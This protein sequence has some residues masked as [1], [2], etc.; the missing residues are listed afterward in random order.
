MVSQPWESLR[1]ISKIEIVPGPGRKGVRAS[2]DTDYEEIVYTNNQVYAT[3]HNRRLRLTDEVV[4][5]HTDLPDQFKKLVVACSG[6]KDQAYEIYQIL[7]KPVPSNWDD[8][9]GEEWDCE[10]SD[11]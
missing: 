6:N 5:T 1:F 7:Q 10:C 8:P 11:W 2:I 4:N 3:G 9:P